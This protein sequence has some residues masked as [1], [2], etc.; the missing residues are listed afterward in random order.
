M[1]KIKDLVFGGVTVVLSI[2]TKY[3]FSET[4]QHGK[5]IAILQNENKNIHNCLSEMKEDLK[6]IRRKIEEV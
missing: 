6:F 2:V 3:I 1:D 4:T 5:D